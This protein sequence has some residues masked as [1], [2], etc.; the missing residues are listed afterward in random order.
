[1]RKTAIIFALIAVSIYGLKA[2]VTWSTNSNG[3]NYNGG[4]VGIGTTNPSTLL[5]LRK[6]VVNSIGPVLLLQNNQYYDNS[7][8]AGSSI[9]FIGAIPERNIEIKGIMGSLAVPERL[10][11][12]INGLN[13]DNCIGEAMVINKTGNVGIGTTNPDK[14]LHI[15]KN[16]ANGEGAFL[17]LENYQYASANN[18]TTGIRF[19]IHPI[20]YALFQAVGEGVNGQVNRLA[21]GLTEHTADTYVER[22]SILHNGNIGIGTTSPTSIFEVNGSVNDKWTSSIK[23]DGG[24]SKGLLVEVGYGGNDASTIMQLGDAN[25]NTRATFKSNGNVGIGITNPQYKLTVEGTIAAREVK[26]T[27]EFWSDFVF[28]PNYKLRTLGEVE[29]FIK[30]NSHLPE[31]PTAAEVKAN[32]VGLGEMNAKLLQKVE[33][34]TLYLIEQNKTLKEQQEEMQL[35]KEEIKELKKK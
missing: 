1:M 12:S 17:H 10:S 26:V 22:L 4:N 7:T 27:A 35:L 29:Q 3:I 13:G 8:N 23:N 11:F 18:A 9:K 33:E 34:L 32:G 31:I 21:I 28:H 5:H 25:G 14:S 19:S 20:R 6:D 15:Q 24:S 16:V 2:Q 30:T